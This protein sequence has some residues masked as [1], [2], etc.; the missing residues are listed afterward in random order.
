[1]HTGEVLKLIDGLTKDG[2]SYFVR[3]GYVK[4]KKIEV[5]N[6]YFNDF[7]EEDVELIKRARKLDFKPEV[8]S[9]KA[10]KGQK[11]LRP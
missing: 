7:S 1:M 8:R 5:D 10:S 4:P 3:A 6:F 11:S 9:Q 2:L